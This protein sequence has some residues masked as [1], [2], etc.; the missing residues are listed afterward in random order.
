MF[1]KRYGFCSLIQQI[2]MIYTSFHQK[3]MSQYFQYTLRNS[4]NTHSVHLFY[5]NQA[6]RLHCKWISVAQMYPT[7]LQKCWCLSYLTR[8]QSRYI[9]QYHQSYEIISSDQPFYRHT[10]DFL[11]RHIHQNLLVCHY[12]A[13]WNWLSKFRYR[14]LDNL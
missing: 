14:V 2:Y 9:H 10:Y 11:S 6:D 7:L 5:S 3:M 13:R 4:N 8:S 12:L 1:D